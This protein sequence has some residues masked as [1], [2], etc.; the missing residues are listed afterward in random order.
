[1]VKLKL[2]PHIFFIVFGQLTQMFCEI[3]CERCHIH[4]LQGMSNRHILL[5]SIVT[6]LVCA[7]QAFFSSNHISAVIHTYHE[8]SIW[9]QCI[10]CKNQV[11]VW[12]SC[13]INWFL[14]W[15][16][17]YITEIICQIML[18]HKI[19]KF[20]KLHWVCRK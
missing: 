12:W 11:D 17:I 20:L 1:M 7:F 18:F 8:V 4:R 14:K 2:I 10:H 16:I 6:L 5:I 15:N 19:L 13:W 3:P 9:L